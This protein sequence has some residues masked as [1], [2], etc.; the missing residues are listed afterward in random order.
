MLGS[1]Q[2]GR[3]LLSTLLLGAFTTPLSVAY[4]DCTCKCV[5]DEPKAVCTL[6]TD[7]APRCPIS[8]CPAAP[9][10]AQP[11]PH[12][13]TTPADDTNSCRQEQVVN[14][15]THQYEWQLICR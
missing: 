6:P 1:K 12:L 14:Q 7:K 13:P 8:S 5:N 10:K 15:K 4:A 9:T 11:A 2:M 3:I